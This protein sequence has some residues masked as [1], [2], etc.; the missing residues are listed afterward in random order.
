MS[1]LFGKWLFQ[2]LGICTLAMVARA[3][4]E[5][6]YKIRLNGLDLSFDRQTGS[7]EYL[8][9]PAT[10][11]LLEATRERSGLLDVAYPIKER[12]V[13]LKPR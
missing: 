10:G 4:D 3:A 11:V 6:L 1:D 8:Y 9:S 2:L 12:L 13:S 7:L 5:S